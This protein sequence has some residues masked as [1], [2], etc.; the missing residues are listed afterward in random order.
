MGRENG[1]DETQARGIGRD[2]VPSPPGRVR[3]GLLPPHGERARERLSGR[4]FLT[5][6]N[7]GVAHLAAFHYFCTV[8][9]YRLAMRH[10]ANG[11]NHGHTG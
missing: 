8:L 5:T 2:T 4:G 11:P 1:A 10:G 6:F 9:I 7:G 3:V